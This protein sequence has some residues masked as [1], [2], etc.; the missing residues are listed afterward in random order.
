MCTAH[1]MPCGLLAPART[2]IAGFAAAILLTLLA[3]AGAAPAAACAFHGPNLPGMLG[4][5]GHWQADGGGLALPGQASALPPADDGGTAAAPVSAETLLE[6]RKA[7]VANMRQL[8]RERYALGD[9]PSA[10]GP[11]GDAAPDLPAGQ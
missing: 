3:L 6:Q 9:A 4:H 10:R 7:A 2:A 5:I 8:F 11:A 1:Q